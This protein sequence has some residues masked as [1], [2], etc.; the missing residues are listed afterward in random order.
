MCDTCMSHLSPNGTAASALAP[1]AGSR[2]VAPLDDFED[3]V[4]EHV[5]HVFARLDQ[6][7]S[8]P[9]EQDQHPA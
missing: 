3:G 2:H 4:E 6:A 9:D 1:H 5:A 8:A 7:E